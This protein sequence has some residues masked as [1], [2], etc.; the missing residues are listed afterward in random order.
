MAQLELPSLDIRYALAADDIRE[1]RARGHVRLRQVASPEEVDAYRPYLIDAVL[2]RQSSRKPLSER[3]TYGRAFLQVGGV[4]RLHPACFAYVVSRRFARIAAELMGVDGVRLYNDQALF[5]EPGGGPTPWH[6]DQVYWPL[7]TPHTITMWMPLVDVPESVGS[8]R[9]ASGS[10]A[11]GE[12]SDVVISD[13]S[14]DYYERYLKTHDLPIVQY[15]A[16]KAGDAT[17][18]A[19]WTL[20][21]AQGNPTDRMR[22]VMTIIYF[23]DGARLTVPDSD[24]RA[25]DLRELFPGQKPGERAGSVANPLLWQRSGESAYCPG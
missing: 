6:Q 23:A 1:Y 21:R 4:R 17:F 13:A 16:M 25:A 19:G 18:H 2:G 10:H 11:L 8:M 9:F 5:K 3:D 24:E 14:Q 15:G 12:I 20:H 7:D 22:A